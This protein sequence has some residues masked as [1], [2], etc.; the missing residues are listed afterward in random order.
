MI[1][2]EI[3]FSVLRPQFDPAAAKFRK[4]PTKRNFD[5]LTDIMLA[6]ECADR[7]PLSVLTKLLKDV[8]P[9]QYVK[10]ICEYKG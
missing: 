2:R 3:I 5:R 10:K 1:R 6:M 8:P 4:R 7:R 9:S